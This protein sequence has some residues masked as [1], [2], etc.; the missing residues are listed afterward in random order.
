[1]VL[2]VLRSEADKSVKM[3]LNQKLMTALLHKHSPL[4]FPEIEKAARKMPEVRFDKSVLG[5]LA[6]G[7]LENVIGFQLRHL[8][9]FTAI[10]GG[11]AAYASMPS[12]R[13]AYSPGQS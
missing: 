5:L 3:Q 9:S 4:L 7:P 11:I 2:A 12:K 6:A 10:S 8:R 13:W 1:M